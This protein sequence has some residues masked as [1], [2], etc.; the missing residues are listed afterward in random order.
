MW[1]GHILQMMPL[2]VWEKIAWMG[3]F[4]CLSGCA[5]VHPDFVIFYLIDIISINSTTS[6][7]SEVTTVFD[8]LLSPQCR[9]IVVS[10]S[11][12]H[13]S[14]RLILISEFDDTTCV[15][16]LELQT[17]VMCLLAGD[18]NERCFRYY[19]PFCWQWDAPT[20]RSVFWLVENLCLGFS[21]LQGL[22]EVS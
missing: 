5:S 6:V 8:S 12:G 18:S 7:F 20:F 15:P 22:I 1:A 9:I 10:A 17:C 13:I 19:L 21:C 4:W 14:K 16:S 11:S 2:L 3:V